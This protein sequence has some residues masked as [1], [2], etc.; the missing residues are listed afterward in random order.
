VRPHSF[1]R[2]WKIHR[3]L[4]GRIP[5][6]VSRL[7]GRGTREERVKNC[8]GQVEETSAKSSRFSGA[9]RPR[10]INHR[11]LFMSRKNLAYLAIS[12]IYKRFLAGSLRNRAKSARPPT[13]FGWLSATYSFDDDPLISRSHARVHQPGEGFSPK[14]LDLGSGEQDAG[15]VRDKPVS[16]WEPSSLVNKSF[17]S[18][19]ERP[20]VHQL[21]SSSLDGARSVIAATALKPVFAP[22]LAHRSAHHRQP[23]EAVGR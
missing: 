14:T 6:F 7:R 2:H 9:R 16:T 17:G 12:T 4:T 10:Y 21:L 8:F 23:L 11:R 18:C 5:S 1:G 19:S 15:V 20:S 22:G 3:N 13:P